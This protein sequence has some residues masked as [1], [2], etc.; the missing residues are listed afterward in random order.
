MHFSESVYAVSGV[1]FA[2]LFMPHAVAILMGLSAVLLYHGV[3]D[4]IV[5]GSLACQGWRFQP[6]NEP[7]KTYGI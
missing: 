4:H 2:A 7:W 5:I 6:I 3:L 1:R